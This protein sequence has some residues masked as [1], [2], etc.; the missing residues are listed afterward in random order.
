[1][2]MCSSSGIGVDGFR[3]GLD[4]FLKLVEHFEGVFTMGWSE[5]G[6]LEYGFL[7]IDRTC[8]GRFI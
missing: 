1:M 7:V 3:V 8:H 5:V 4:F 2:D 6:L